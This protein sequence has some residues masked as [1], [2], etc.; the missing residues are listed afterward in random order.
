M[1]EEGPPRCLKSW[2]PHEG[3]PL[4][5]LL[6]L[7][8]HTNPSPDSRFWKFVIT[9]CTANSELK[10]WCSSSWTCLQTIKFKRPESDEDLG[11]RLK[12]VLD[13]TAQFLVLS[14]IDAR[15]IFVLNIVQ[16]ETRA[17]VISV[18]EFASP[19]AAA[20]RPRAAMPAKFAAVACGLGGD[21]QP[22]GIALLL[23][24]DN[25]LRAEK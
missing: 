21:V 5:S 17:E 12:A 3:K 7:D 14:D 20:A 2:S 4:S 22:S 8:D 19:T 1:H 24:Q 11:V 23:T 18:G 13:P 6:W 16:T 9:G 15:L 25:F 10:V